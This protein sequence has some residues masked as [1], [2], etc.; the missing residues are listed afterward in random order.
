MH[1]SLYGF[2]EGRVMGTATLE[3]KMDQ[4]IAGLDHE[5][6]FQVFYR[7]VESV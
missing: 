1:D 4:Q 5:P 6:L 2:Q 3:A 7:R